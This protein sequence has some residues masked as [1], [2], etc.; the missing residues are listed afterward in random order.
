VARG[1]QKTA[2]D[3]AQAGIASADQFN[4]QTEQQNAAIQNS[5]IPAYTSLINSP[6]YSS[7]Q[8]SAITNASEGSAAAAF[9][10]AGDA[11][12]RAAARTGNAAALTPDLD[13]LAQQKASTMSS[14][15]ANDQVTFAND[16]QKQQQAGLQGMSSLYGVDQNMLA[17][18]LGLPVEYLQQYNTAA[19]K[20][21]ATQGII[22]SLIGG[23]AQ[24]GAAKLGGCWIAE[25]IYGEDDLRTHAVRLWLNL[26]FTKCIAGRIVMAA[27][28][29]FGQ[30]IAARVRRSGR[31]RFLLK[32]LFDLAL[33]KALGA[34]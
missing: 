28:L 4:T 11:A 26:E 34:Q 31:L 22:Q 17:K 8:Q 7:S 21:T 33:N 18:S 3:T 14:V 19:A 15:A 1:A 29:R 12:S 23:A 13:K 2:E 20:P 16:Q 10:G 25:A 9:S 6:G 27:Y 30:R 24:V 32:P 5:L